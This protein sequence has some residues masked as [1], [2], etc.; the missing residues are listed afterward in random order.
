MNETRLPR[1]KVEGKG[2]VLYRCATCDRLMDPADAVMVSG[3]S[4]HPDHLPESPD[5]R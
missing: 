3:K 2:K 5:G 4:Y 1:P